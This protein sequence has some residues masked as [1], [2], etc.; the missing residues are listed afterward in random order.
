MSS[1]IRR[2]LPLAFFLAL[3]ALARAQD[4]PESLT[5]WKPIARNPVFAGTGRDLSWDFKIRERGWILFEDGVFHLWYTGYNDARSPL[6]RLGYA[7]SIDGMSWIRCPSNPIVADAWVEDVCVVKQGAVYHMFAEGEK[8]IAHRLTSTDRV[9]WTEQG[10]LDI[11]KVDGNPIPPGP[12]GTP[13]AYLEGETWY[14]FYERGDR[15][16]WL[17]TSKDFKVWTHVQDEPVMEMGP[18][19]YDRHAVAMDQVFK[20]DGT[21]FAYYHANAHNPWKK[22]WTT[23]LARSKDLV[24]WEK[25]PGNPLVGNDSSSSQLLRVGGRNRLY[26]M[27]PEVRVFE[28][29]R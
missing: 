16:V 11:R 5:K 12:R 8:D 20:L 27:H 3:A 22:D 24:H 21:Y 18:D 9:T 15:G 13:V 23:N 7:V 17:A 25:F 26:T 28:P 1:P 10:P 4:F 19:A 14:L 6:R 2:T 29:R